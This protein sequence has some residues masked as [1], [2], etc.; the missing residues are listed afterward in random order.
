MTFSTE[1]T[2]RSITVPGGA[3]VEY[4]LRITTGDREERFVVEARVPWLDVAGGGSPLEARGEAAAHP[5]PA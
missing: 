5:R 2:P 4:R 3:V 1:T